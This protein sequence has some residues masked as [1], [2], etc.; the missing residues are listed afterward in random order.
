MEESRGYKFR[1]GRFFAWLPVYLLIGFA[2]Y[3]LSAGPFY[4]KIYEAYRLDGSPYLASLYLPLVVLSEVS[5]TFGQ[6]MDWYVGLW[7]L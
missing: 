7:V 6:W 2:L 3:V 1:W 4:W 5:D